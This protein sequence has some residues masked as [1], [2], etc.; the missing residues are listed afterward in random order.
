MWKYT[1]ILHPSSAAL[2]YYLTL[3]VNPSDNFFAAFQPQCS[4]FQ[5]RASDWIPA[6]VNQKCCMAL[7]DDMLYKQGG[8]QPSVFQQNGKFLRNWCMFV[9]V[10]LAST[11]SP[12]GDTNFLSLNC[13]NWIVCFKI[14]YQ[15]LTLTKTYPSLAYNI[16]VTTWWLPQCLPK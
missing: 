1:C 11:K 12:S 5:N 4:L 13:E 16:L 9:P 3:F 10:L 7:K 14:L 8:K 6:G 15:W 2:I